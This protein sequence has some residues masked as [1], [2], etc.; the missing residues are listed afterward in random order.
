MSF[1][2]AKGTIFVYRIEAESTSF[3]V[4]KTAFQKVSL[5]STYIPRPQETFAG[6]YSRYPKNPSL[7]LFQEWPIWNSFATVGVWDFWEN[8]CSEA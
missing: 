3:L 5:R 2:C 7:Q 6:D 4:K 8:G 1:P